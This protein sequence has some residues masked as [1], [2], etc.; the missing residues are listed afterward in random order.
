MECDLPGAGIGDTLEGITEMMEQITDFSHDLLLRMAYNACISD[1]TVSL[2]V[3]PES[4]SISHYVPILNEMLLNMSGIHGIH[5]TEYPHKTTIQLQRRTVPPTYSLIHILH[6]S[7]D[8][9][10]V[11]GERYNGV[12]I[13]YK[14]LEDI[15]DFRLKILTCIMDRARV[16]KIPA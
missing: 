7:V 3:V 11:F 6:P 4:T 13:Y 14:I 16:Y 1:P 5:V 12:I 10:Y 9:K 8:G 15:L 2:L